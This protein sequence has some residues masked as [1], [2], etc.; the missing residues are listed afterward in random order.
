MVMLRR[1]GLGKD[2][3]AFFGIV[4]RSPGQTALGTPRFSPILGMLVCDETC[5]I[6]PSLRSR[7]MD[8]PCTH[9][10]EDYTQ[11]QDNE[12][13]CGFTLTNSTLVRAIVRA[14]IDL[15]HLPLIL[16]Q[17][18][19]LKSTG[20]IVGAFLAS[21]VAGATGS[22]VN[23]IE[24]GHPDV[25]PS[26]ADGA[27]EESLRNYPEGLEIKG[28]CGNLPKGLK[29]SGG[30]N[31]CAF[32]RGVTWQA[33]HRQVDKLLGTIWDFDCVVNEVPSPTITAAFYSKT[34][35]PD[36][37]GAISG[38]TGRNTKV[39]GMLQSGKKKMTAGVVCILDRNGYV[40]RYAKIFRDLA[41][42]I[43]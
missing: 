8:N 22:I 14:N 31:R 25:V 15:A 18:I 13:E 29:L 27:S 43:D 36:D 37:W 20:S 26:D 19:D 35:V 7:L 21:A 40:Q 28:T 5:S 30:E 34:L 38:T 12:F 2:P 11:P 32:L 17:R 4:S 24:K 1:P 9:S 42:L 6:E 39:S 16:W 10:I 3:Y 41:Q 23:P 33:H